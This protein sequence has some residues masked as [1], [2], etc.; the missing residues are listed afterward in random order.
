MKVRLSFFCLILVLV[1]AAFVVDV[2]FA[3]SPNSPPGQRVVT[4]N[5]TR[6]SDGAAV[7]DYGGTGFSVSCQQNRASVTIPVDP[8]DNTYSVTMLTTSQS[9][10]SVACV[11]SGERR[12]VAGRCGDVILTIH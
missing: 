4:V 8:A 3:L 7:G 1:V 2:T 12:S 10:Q 6:G 11:V 5:C 9:G